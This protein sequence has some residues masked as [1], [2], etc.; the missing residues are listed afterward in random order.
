MNKD[1]KSLQELYEATLS[2]LNDWIGIGNEHIIKGANM[3]EEVF[4]YKP[5]NIIEGVQ[6]GE[7]GNKSYVI[8]SVTSNNEVIMVEIIKPAK[9]IS[10]KMAEI[11]N[12]V[13]R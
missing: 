3:R 11:N 9:V 12:K 1:E 8:I 4:N 7:K 5:G 10:A 13:R 2:P 6:L